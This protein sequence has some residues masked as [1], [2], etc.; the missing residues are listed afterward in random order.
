MKERDDDERSY[1]EIEPP[2]RRRP[3]RRRHVYRPPL[4][5]GRI[6]A[7]TGVTLA[8]AASIGAYF[9]FRRVPHAVMLGPRVLVAAASKQ[10]AEAMVL[11][12]RKRYAKTAPQTVSFRE[13]V[14]TLVPL[15]APMVPLERGAGVDT[16][17]RQLTAVVAGAGINVGGRTLLM[18]PDEEAAAQTIA[19]ALQRGAA[20]REGIPT[21]KERV[22]V[23]SRTQAEG[24]T[25]PLPMMTPEEAAEF[26]VHPA[27][28]R[29]YTVKPGDNFW[30]I[31]NAHGITI[32]QLRAM[33]PGVDPGT[34]QPGDTVKL[35][36]E[37][38]PMTVVLR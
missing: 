27:V 17:D 19:L 18:L 14:V 9:T 35:P 25:H 20:G 37:P 4:P 1:R 24:D 10:D 38:C 16:L 7:I 34:L 15:R 23:T 32:M 8:L 12:L 13:G 36:D 29:E 22:Y 26:L 31:A 11:E 6:L 2:R 28:P 33:N 30:A 3:R 21:C 5:W